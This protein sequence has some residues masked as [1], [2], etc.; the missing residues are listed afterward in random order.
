MKT[1]KK[2]LLF[3]AVI[4]VLSGVFWGYTQQ[5]VVESDSDDPKLIENTALKEVIDQCN[6]ITERAAAHLV[7]VVEFQK[8][9][10]IGRKARVFKMCLQDHD[11]IENK[12]WLTY[13][14]P[15]AEKAATEKNT[16]VNEAL[17]NLRRADMVISTVNSD[18]PIYWI[19][20]EKVKLNSSS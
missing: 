7:A 5:A 20:E 19:K 6:D 12:Q 1:S 10:I 18:K 11:Y 3:I 16:S 13:S 2:T 4:A 17:E 9:E 8:L 14:Q 15:V